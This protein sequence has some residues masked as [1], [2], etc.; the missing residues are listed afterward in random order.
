MGTVPKPQDS[1]AVQRSAAAMGR[2]DLGGSSCNNSQQKATSPDQQKASS[3]SLM[4]KESLINSAPLILESRQTENATSKLYTNGDQ[5]E[6]D[7]GGEIGQWIKPDAM[8][9]SQQGAEKNAQN[10]SE[11]IINQQ[12]KYVHQGQP[13][14]CPDPG[15]S[16]TNRQL[17]KPADPQLM[18]TDHQQTKHTDPG[19]TGTDHQQTK[20][21]DPGHTRTD[22][23][24]TKPADPG[25]TGTDHQQTKLAD[26]GHTGT[27]HQQSKPADPKHTG[28]DHQQTKSADPGHT[29]T[30]QQQTKPADPRHTGT[31]HQQTKSADPGHTGT[32]QQQNKHT[33]PGH[34]GT[35][36]QQ[37][38]P[39]DPGCTGTDH[40]QTKPVDPRHSGT[41][42]QKTKPA[43][44]GHTGTDHQQTKHTDPGPTGSDYQQTNPADPGHTGTGTDHQQTNRTDPG[45]TG[46]DHQQNKHTD[47]GPTWTDHQNTEHVDLGYPG[48]SYQKISIE[49]REE[50]RVGIRTDVEQLESAIRDGLQTVTVKEETAFNMKTGN[51]KEQLRPTK[52]EAPPKTGPDIPSESHVQKIGARGTQVST[53][54]SSR[55]H[56]QMQPVDTE[57]NLGGIGQQ[58]QQ[59]SKFKDA[60]TMTSQSPGSY[61]PFI[62]NKSCRDVEVQ[63]VLQS[64]QCK[65]TATSP[66]SPAPGS[67]S[68]CQVV[69]NVYSESS[70]SKLSQSARISD[71]Y[72]ESEQLKV[73]CTFTEGSEHSNVVYELHEELVGKTKTESFLSEVTY[74]NKT[75]N[76]QEF[77]KESDYDPKAI[78]VK[79]SELT[80][81]GGL[82]DCGQASSVLVT[83]E[84]ES[85]T[86]VSAKLRAEPERLKVAV[87][88][89]ERSMQ[90]H[91]PCDNSENSEQPNIN[92][93][94][95]QETGV[96]TLLRCVVNESSQCFYDSSRKSAIATN[97]HEK[98]NQK[99]TAMDKSSQSNSSTKISRKND[100]LHDS[101]T[102]FDRF[103][104]WPESSGQSGLLQKPDP[105]TMAPDITKPS[106]CL[107]TVGDIQIDSS[108]PLSI[109]TVPKGSDQSQA[110]GDVIKISGQ[111][112]NV[113][114]IKREPD[115]DAKKQMNQTKD[116]PANSESEDQPQGVCNDSEA[117]GPMEGPYGITVETV[118]PEANQCISVLSGHPKDEHDTNKKVSQSQAVD[119]VSKECEQ[120]KNDSDISKTSAQ[121]ITLYND[122][123][124]FTQSEAG[125]ATIKGSGQSKTDPHVSKQS[126]FFE[127]KKPKPT[128]E[129]NVEPKHSDSDP[130][131]QAVQS[132]NVRDVVWDEQ[133]MT[134]EVY[135]ASLDPESLGFAIQCHLQRQ[136]VEYEKQIKVNNQSKRSASLDATPGSNKANKRRQ[137]NIFRTVLQNMR[138]PQC[139]LRPQ[140][141][142]VID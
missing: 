119:S 124:G 24:Q 86:H 122:G 137:Q 96:P 131:K 92:N 5:A 110:P 8:N 58:Q 22:Q 73:T 79:K 20:S 129:V 63:A 138:S 130:D 59:E 56:Q 136:I 91:S 93:S 94:G 108:G 7:G 31:D 126:H 6:C 132:K 66:Q 101:I 139:C 46:T 21:A 34:T 68:E 62:W 29:G 83:N 78:N 42:H 109:G 64:F 84:S 14:I 16:G 121:V 37:T 70:H 118:Q 117:S 69:Q 102:K 55:E 123:K 133:G 52:E 53:Q 11:V 65:S 19:P 74:R 111:A 135:G 2:K 32:D 61:F 48:T 54:Y 72:H 77:S 15:L 45:H 95:N 49:R 47:P 99:E 3:S 43:D 26:P 28:T 100:H 18:G 36:H 27:D 106:F 125:C 71:S 105:S 50:K 97:V 76:A 89:H 23:Q 30:D 33:D 112:H 10:S 87:E 40:Q 115:L 17:I 113:Y 1:Q 25:H 140:P 104:M 38:K 85:G 90:S 134:W 41:D 80:N 35:D 39:A 82:T 116:L 75:E 103:K 128:I 142:S 57:P 120:P 9:S 81:A 141:S 44:P 13:D 98:S 12:T 127:T 51:R 67:M 114:R 88:L 107:K 4:L 60:E